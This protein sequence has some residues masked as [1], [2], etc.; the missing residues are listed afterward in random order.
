MRINSFV[1][2][3]LKI[4]PYNIFYVFFSWVLG[5]HAE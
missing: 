1:S 4:W 3:Q 5:E 2:S